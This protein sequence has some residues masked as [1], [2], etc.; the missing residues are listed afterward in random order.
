MRNGRP[1][2]LI[3]SLALLSIETG[4]PLGAAEAGSRE[5]SLTLVGTARVDITP[6][7]PVRLSGYSARK[8]ES[9][10]TIQRLWAKAVV[11]GTDAQG[12]AILMSVETCVLPGHVTEELARRL[13]IKAGIARERLVLTCT[14]THTA[15][16]LS[17]GLPTMFGEPIPPDH[18]ARIDAYTQRLIEQLEQVAAEALASRKPA[19]LA[20]GQGKAGFAMNRRLAG[21]T[22]A[23][24]LR[25]N[26]GGPADHAMP[27]L[28]IADESGSLRA[29]VVNYACHCT[30]LGSD[31][32]EV[33]GD[34]A[35]Y[36]QEYVEQEHAGA[37]CMVT[38]GCGADA[39]PEP[40]L[41][42]DH[43]RQ[44]GRSIAD[45]VERVLGDPLQPLSGPPACRFEPIPLPLDV[46]PR[47]EW[48][49]RVKRGGA[50]AYQAKLQLEKLDRGEPLKSELT[51]PVQTWSFGDDLAMVFLGGEVVVDYALRL[52]RE[53]AGD[54]L[55]VTGYANDVAC[56]IASKR[57]L[58]EGGYEALDSM[59]Y[60]D[61][62]G[63]LAPQ[64][65]DLIVSAVRRLLPASL[66]RAAPATS[67]AR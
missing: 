3:V 27:L 29:V 40:R 1:S 47:T 46:F 31:V 58:A 20:W 14:H 52:K 22:G 26:P 4:V 9:T 55:W 28:R 21:P 48:E 2:I 25:P 35:G 30:T 56:Y 12:P 6:D 23:I 11:F 49:A 66:A 15:P 53:L 32:Y 16:C 43:A 24:Q 5:A 38:I 45:E 57:V 54:R 60:Y 41:K 36:A 37:L 59:I 63:R 67:P 65:E 7:H 34:W 33:C 51:Y 10:G 8:T 44:H 62:P 18:Q 42:L 17:G 64:V 19:R 13:Q 50:I 39:N 61:Q